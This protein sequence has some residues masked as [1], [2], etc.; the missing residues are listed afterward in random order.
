MVLAVVIFAWASVTPGEAL[1]SFATSVS[2][3]TTFADNALNSVSMVL[4]PVKY[5]EESAKLTFPFVISSTKIPLP[6]AT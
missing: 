1:E 6:Q 5:S 3:L 2:R 4:T